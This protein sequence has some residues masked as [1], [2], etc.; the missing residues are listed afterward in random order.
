MHALSCVGT[1]TG[2]GAYHRW[3]LELAKAAH[4]AFVITHPDNP[5]RR[6]VW[7]MSVDLTYPLVSSMGQHDPLDGFVT[8]LELVQA[9]PGEP[10]WPDLESEISEMISLCQGLPW[11]TGD[12]LG[13]GG[14]LTDAY[15]LA[16][17]ALHQDGKRMRLL[18]GVLEACAASLDHYVLTASLEEP[19]M[20]RLAFRE[21][22]L[23][24]GLRAAGLLKALVESR[25]THLEDPVVPLSSVEDIAG[26]DT[27]RETIETQWLKAA[28]K[29]HEAWVSHQD[30]NAVM[31][32]TSLAP[33]SYLRV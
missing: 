8:Y 21:L 19:L 14:L 33:E 26:H 5:P 24:L 12:A 17:L 29:G 23:A 20:Y 4:Q 15:R 18:V 27:L 10:S 22:G 25:H 30:I 32:A 7:K 9:T 6:M 1:V 31:L 13:I 3:A 16:Q 28:W 2:R 11:E